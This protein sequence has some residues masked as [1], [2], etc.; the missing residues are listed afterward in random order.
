MHSYFVCPAF[1]SFV[2]A[3]LFPNFRS[4]TKL[5]VYCC[6]MVCCMCMFVAMY[7]HYFARHRKNRVSL[8]LQARSTV[9]YLLDIMMVKRSCSSYQCLT[10]F[11]SC[12]QASQA[13]GPC[14][15]TRQLATSSTLG[16]MLLVRRA[17]SP[18]CDA[19]W[20]HMLGV[21]PCLVNCSLLELI[22]GQQQGTGACSTMHPQQHVPVYT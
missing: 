12:S 5:A 17:H 3:L 16:R 6:T 2:A 11:L 9:V 19:S 4:G 7:H 1:C 15:I 8:K 14:A 18:L 22:Q 21:M 20:Q 13:H 10:A